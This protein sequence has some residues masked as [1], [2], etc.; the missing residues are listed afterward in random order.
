MAYMNSLIRWN[1]KSLEHL[2]VIDEDYDWNENYMSQEDMQAGD[3]FLD[4]FIYA[5]WRCANLRT[6]KIGKFVSSNRSFLG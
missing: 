4:P 6:I 5:A 3:Q 2:E 1:E